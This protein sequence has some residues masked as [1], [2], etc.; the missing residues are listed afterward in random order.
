MK[1]TCLPALAAFPD[2]RAHWDRL[3]AEL[4]AGH[5]MFDSRFIA[6]LLRYFGGE[7][8]VLAVLE[9]ADGVAGLT[10][11]E[12]GRPG[13]WH[14]FLPSQL[15]VAPILLPPSLFPDTGKLFGRLPGAPVLA[16]DWLCQDAPYSPCFSGHAGAPQEA[17]A[18]ATTMNVDTCRSFSDYW[19]HRSKNLRQNLS[20]LQ[21]K[22]E[23]ERQQT[24]LEVLTGE[25]EVL[26]ILTRFGLM[27][28]AGW[29]GKNGT[30]I[31]PD[32]TQGRFYA[33]VLSAFA[34]TGQARAYVLYQNERLA[35]IKL[36]IQN[37]R[38]LVILKTSYDEALAD[39]SPGRIL[40]YQLFQ[41]ELPG[42]DFETIEFYNH[43]NAD[44]LRWS[45]GSRPI[46]H[47]SLYRNTL[48][49]GLIGLVHRLRRPGA[50]PPAESDPAVT[51]AEA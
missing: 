23:R 4:Y 25:A 9:S 1:W 32:N 35:S 47:L 50:Q 26:D 34:R 46:R 29:K 40:Q 21:H 33:E 44:A 37:E 11:L 5:P 28:S 38:M 3:N 17:V 22:L 49:Q 8:T 42:R 20:R 48:A 12:P 14:S 15:Q 24:R 7:K 43:A 51:G 13:Q 10:L 36:C 39:Y 41:R 19:T 16:I 18:H 45:T 2:Y 6:P 31:H 27:E 30:A